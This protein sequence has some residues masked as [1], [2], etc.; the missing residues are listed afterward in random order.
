MNLI[1]RYDGL[2]WN[3]DSFKGSMMNGTGCI[4]MSVNRD[5]HGSMSMM[6]LHEWPLN[7]LDCIRSITVVITDY[8]YHNVSS[9]TDNIVSEVW[10]RS[11]HHQFSR[12]SFDFYS[13]CIYFF[14]PNPSST[15]VCCLQTTT[16]RENSRVSALLIACLC[17]ELLI[18]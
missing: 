18:E 14:V 16:H 11:S 1:S 12:S 10:Q 3:I 7:F 9:R 6:M 17:C 13:L 8:K 15:L 4:D 2:K 5:G